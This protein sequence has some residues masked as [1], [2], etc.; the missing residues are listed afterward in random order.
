M[1][2]FAARK[3]FCVLCALAASALL[4]NTARAG[5]A[6]PF[7]PPLPGDVDR[8]TTLRLA[9]ITGD[10]SQIPALIA[11]LGSPSESVETTALLALAQMGATEALP[12]VGK[13]IQK[14]PNPWTGNYA[15]AARAR[16]L[17]EAKAR[18][19]APAG[20]RLQ[21]RVAAFLVAVKLRPAQIVGDLEAQRG[22]IP[23]PV[24][25]TLT[26]CACE[27]IADMI[28]RSGLQY[29]RP[30]P[31]LRGLRFALVPGAR[32]KIQLAQLP[33]GQRLPWMIARIVASP[34]S[35]IGE[36]RLIQLA[37]DEGRPASRAAA[38]KL[39]EIRAHRSRYPSSG[40]AGLFDVI[41]S[42]GDPAQASLVRSFTRDGDRWV[43]FVAGDSW[44]SIARGQ[45]EQVLTGY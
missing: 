43:A 8:L 9:G 30:L 44:P 26:V 10:Q 40:F 32:L 36:L 18:V 31:V 6:A 24:G 7:A 11:A 15:R 16:L 21:I 33:K 23:R 3:A 22:Q 34:V 17:A 13:I 38:A 42:A 25:D 35:G 45:R 37:A 2:T 1:K 41:R 5:W 14:P 27:E 20:A 19:Q 29:T 4:S 39:K 28:Y 12:A